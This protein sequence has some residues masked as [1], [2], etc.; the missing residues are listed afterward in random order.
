MCLQYLD[1]ILS[2]VIFRLRR[3]LSEYRQLM[4]ARAT[5]L[6]KVDVKQCSI[7]TFH[8]DGL[9]RWITQHIVQIWHSVAHQRT[10]SLTIVLHK[11]ITS[12][13]SYRQAESSNKSCFASLTTEHSRFYT[14]HSFSHLTL[15]PGW[16]QMHADANKFHSQQYRKVLRCKTLCGTRPNLD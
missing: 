14:F 12:Y 5:R 11:Q 13:E 3:S 1:V 2:L 15:L 8:D 4:I 9:A 7:G 10:N 16:Q 6:T